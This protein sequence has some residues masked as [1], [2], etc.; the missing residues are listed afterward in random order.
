MTERRSDTKLLIGATVAV[1]VAGLI[2]AAAILLVTGRAKTPGLDKPIPF[3]IASSLRAKV[4]E[5][6]PILFAGT[7][8]DTGFWLILEDGRLVALD[9][10]KPTEKTCNIK[11]RSSLDAFTDCH[12]RKVTP[13][14][15]ARFRTSV[16]KRGDQKG[17]FLVDLRHLDPAPG[18]SS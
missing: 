7:T 4:K 5:G 14:S 8:G 17:F 2:I 16:P 3:G 18:P 13:E 12:G 10:Q 1:L 11:F 9:V 6:G 15:M